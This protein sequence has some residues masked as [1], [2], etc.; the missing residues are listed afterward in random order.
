MNKRE[1]EFC[2]LKINGI[3]NKDLCKMVFIE[4]LYLCLKSMAFMLILNIFYCLVNLEL[5]LDSQ[6]LICISQMLLFILCLA[7]N[8]YKIRMIY[9]DKRLRN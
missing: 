9:P 7:Y 8:I 1:I 2:L 4:Q 5:S 6:F 3:S